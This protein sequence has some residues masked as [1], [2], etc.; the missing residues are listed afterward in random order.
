LVLEKPP[1][2]ILTIFFKILGG[3]RLSP[4]GTAA[5]IGLLYHPQMIDDDDCGAIGGIKLAGETE[6][7]RENLPQ[8]YF[9][10]HKSHMTIFSL[11]YKCKYNKFLIIHANRGE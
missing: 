7:L 3:V 10:L 4:L 1:T 5:T 8:S 6:V 11:Y 9:V 2:V